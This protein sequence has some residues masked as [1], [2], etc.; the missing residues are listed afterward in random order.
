MHR[1]LLLNS[2]PQ[3]QRKFTAKCFPRCFHF[4]KRL[5]IFFIIS[6]TLNKSL[7][8][9]SRAIV[10]NYPFKIR[11]FLGA[12]TFIYSLQRMRTIEGWG[13]DSKSRATKPDTNSLIKIL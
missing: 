5:E 11:K 3:R 4:C 10:N 1:Q 8:I 13:T 6:Q 12:Q 7:R 2:P 9:I